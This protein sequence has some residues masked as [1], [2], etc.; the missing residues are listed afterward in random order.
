M[1]EIKQ[2]FKNHKF[3]VLLLSL[4]FLLRI[5]SLFEPY[6]YGDE[7]IYLS[8]GLAIRKGFLLYRDV[9]DNKP[10]MIYLIAAAANGTI[11]WFRF[12]LMISTL[13]A[14]FFF[15]RVSQL[16]FEGKEK[17]ARI[18]V[19]VF[20]L[21]TTIRLFEGN[22]ANS[23]IFILFPTAL[24]FFLI[25]KY[26]DKLKSKRNFVIPIVSGVILSMGFLLKV[27]ALFELL[28]ISFF[29]VFLND[30]KKFINFGRKEILL[31]VGYFIPILLT[32]L[33]FYLKGAFSEYFNAV[34]VQTMGYLSSWK[35]GTHT[36]S[37]MH[38]LKTELAFKGILVAII[39]VLL[40]IRKKN[41]KQSLL[42]ISVWFVFSLFGATLSGRPYGHYLIQVVPP[43][44]LFFGFITLKKSKSEIL[45]PVCFLVLFGISFFYYHFWTYTTIPYYQ[46]FI[47]VILG[48]KNKNSYLTY[49][50]QDLPK[51]YQIGE[52]IEVYSKPSDKI[53]IWGDEP[54]LYAMLK[55]LP[56]TPYLA[57]YHIIDLNMYDKTIIDLLSQNPA[58][59]VIDSSR[60]TFP[61][62]NAL[63]KTS[64]I[65]VESVGNF[66]IFSKRKI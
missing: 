29:L 39:C 4:V 58:L 32:G 43:L 44:S 14:T 65:R 61:Q 8:I 12:L 23:E 51:L 35:T 2:I 38:L 10:P 16:I 53:F 9:F 36:F 46:N 7:G 34:F 52:K 63:V 57:S 42:F 30:R 27:L 33:F 26:F 59:I 37:L 49:F 15:Y 22:I 3:I 18:S 17:N 11:F 50:S 19:V 6:W 64:Y 62:L 13:N 45:I 31:F 47:E 48:Q 28:T 24:G 21:L 25:F 66:S 5:P 60:K 56:A 20:S 55:R 41:L 54:S 40:W 1:K